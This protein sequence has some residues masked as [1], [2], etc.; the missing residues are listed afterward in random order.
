MK[1]RNPFA[2]RRVRQAVYQGIDIGRIVEELHGLGVP[3]GMGIWPKG[4]GWSEELD[5]RLPY[6]PAKAK[7]LLAEAGYP[8]GFDV[9]F[10]CWA[11][12]EPVC[13]MIGALLQEIGIQV[14]VAPLP[15]FE[16]GQHSVAGGL[17]DV[18]AAA[19][20]LGVEQL[21][22]VPLLA[23]EHALLILLHEPAV[24]RHVGDEDGRELTLHAPSPIKPE[25]SG[26]SSPNPW[27]R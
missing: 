23:L 10:D 5:R 11:P 21:P 17:D 7:A 4:I 6:D 25:A 13:R 8:E 15:T 9:R 16:L 26:A 12:R 24:A 18:P 19:R 27:T 2:D 20:D 1:G 22:P 3:A 14:D